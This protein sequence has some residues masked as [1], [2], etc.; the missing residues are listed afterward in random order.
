MKAFI[1]NLK[2]ETLKRQKVTERCN[3]LGLDYEIIDAVVGKDIQP[4]VIQAVAYH[5][6]KSKI[7]N[8][9]VGCTLSHLHIYTRIVNEHIPYALIMEDDINIHESVLPIMDSLEKNIQPEKEEIFLLNTPEAITPLVSR[10]I[11]ENYKFFRMA[12]ASQSPGYIITKKTAQKL[13]SF[14]FP[15]KYEVDRW[16]AFR[17]YCGIKIWTLEQGVIDT[18]DNDKSES[19]LEEDRSKCELERL[20]FLSKLRKTEKNYQ[21]RRLI[22]LLIKKISNKDIPRHS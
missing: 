16:M 8:G 18:Y 17:D 4:E 9:V 3:T 20:N 1:I 22:N 2:S 21:S 15:I 5:H 13:L 10:T 11:G 7:T 19:S 12:R 6:S 14:N